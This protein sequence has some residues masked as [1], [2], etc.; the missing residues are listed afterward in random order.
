MAS[1]ENASHLYKAL[2]REGANPPADFADRLD[3]AVAKELGTPDAITKWGQPLPPKPSVFAMSADIEALHATVTLWTH[4]VELPSSLV[5]HLLRQAGVE[6]TPAVGRALRFVHEDVVRLIV[7]QVEAVYQH[8]S[9]PIWSAQEIT[10]LLSTTSVK[11]EIKKTLDRESNRI[12][13][14]YSDWKPGD[15]FGSVTP[16]SQHITA[17]R[18]GPGF[19]IVVEGR[20]VIPITLEA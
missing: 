18:R 20:A 11:R 10:N 5:P 19:T 9:S 12:Q 6:S 13:K 17:A 4:M 16:Y 15:R 1:S 14:T 2:L 8:A 3:K 7:R